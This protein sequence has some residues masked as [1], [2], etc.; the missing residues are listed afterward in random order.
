MTT[1]PN[2]RSQPQTPQNFSNDVFKGQPEAHSSISAYLT[3]NT[4]TGDTMASYLKNPTKYLPSVSVIEDLGEAIIRITEEAARA[5]LYSAYTPTDKIAQLGT[6][7]SVEFSKPLN[8]LC[9]VIYGAATKEN[10]IECLLGQS[11][12]SQLG[13]EDFLRAAIA[14]AVYD[15]VLQGQHSPLPGDLF[16]LSVIGSI[17][18]EVASSSKSMSQV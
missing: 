2:L 6:S 3:D 8:D 18:H 5:L 15:W 16:E 10:L 11:F 17:Y 9:Y 12:H 4:M 1:I 13:L 14:A 7:L